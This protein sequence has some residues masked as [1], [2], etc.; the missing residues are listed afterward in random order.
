MR[1]KNVSQEIIISPHK[2]E[3]YYT[4]HLDKFKLEDRVKLR[5]IVR[6]NST[7]PYATSPKKMAEEVLAKIKGGIP[8]DEMAKSYSQGSQ[9]AEGGDA[10]WMDKATLRKELAEI[11][12]SLKSGE[13][14]DVIE[15]SDGCYIIRVEEISPTHYR[16]LAE[17][18]DEIEKDL[19]TEERARLEKQWLDKLRK[20]TFVKYYY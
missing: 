2:I 14:S 4:N 10:G 6:T 7:D 17:V 11:A 19:A 5:M 9:R 13:L 18:R 12:F 20:K 16:S 15:T 8:F 1:A 3:L